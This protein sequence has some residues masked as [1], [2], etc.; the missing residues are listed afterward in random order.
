MLLQRRGAVGWERSV[1]IVPEEVHTVLT[2]FDLV[3]V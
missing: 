1:E 2:A 3:L